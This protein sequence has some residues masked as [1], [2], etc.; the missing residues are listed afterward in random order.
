MIRPAFRSPPGGDAL[1][2]VAAAAAGTH[3]LEEVLEVAAEEARAAVNAASLSVSRYEREAGMLRTIINVGALGP[4]EERYPADEVYPVVDDQVNQR[5]FHDGV[6]FFNSIDDGQ[7]PL[8]SVALLK[9]LRKESHVG[10][11]ILVEDVVWGEV[12]ATTAPGQPRFRGEDVRFLEAVAGQLALAIGRAELFTRVSRLA[13]EDSLTG[14]ANR[15]ALDERLERAVTR[16]KDRG[17]ALAVLLCDVDELKA[18]NDAAGHAA[19]DRALRRVG[20]ALVAASATR[21]GSLVGRLA[22]DEFCVVMDGGGLAEARAVAAATMRS[23]AAGPGRNILVSCGAAAL[24]PSV[25]TPALLLRAADAA[26]YRAKRNGGGQI[27]TAGSRAPEPPAEGERRALRRSLPDRVRDAVHDVCRRFERDLEH[28]GP[29]ER[30]EAVAI[31]LSVALDATAWA[32]SV[33]PAGGYT[34]HTVS[35]ADDREQRLQGLH[36]E[37]DNDV[38]SIDDY[39]AT[40]RLI[41]AGAGAFVTRVGDGEADRAE[42]ALLEHEGRAGVLVAAAAGD[43]STWLLEIYA[44]ERSSALE[45]AALECAMLMRSAM[46]PRPADGGS[47][48]LLARRT[49]QVGLTSVLAAGLPAAGGPEEMAALVADELYEVMAV[50]AAGVMRLRSGNGGPGELFDMTAGRG[51]FAEPSFA[52]FVQPSY[53]GLVGRCLRERGPVLATDVT[54]EPDFYSVPATRDVRSELDVPV[55]VDG[56][57]WGAITVQDTSLAAF[58]EADA[59]LLVTVA[60]QLAAALRAAKA[61]N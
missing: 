21:P 30:V 2:R 28:S 17:G 23:L 4:G 55:W 36:V 49:R 14:L 12:Y 3:E 51:L 7:A 20:E 10:V 41:Q 15:R 13:Y 29:L 44:D 18:I 34:I 60:G 22:G 11:A 35:L 48:A 39:P 46:P 31:A 26:L 6:S 50:S 45:E 1:L 42:R 33:V 54:T 37:F 59:R 16:A 25:A 43:D 32:V 52:G 24:E 5:L 57:P 9:R 58:D 27:F 40:A 38:Y 53:Q 56:R 47:A 8:W 19:G 61:P